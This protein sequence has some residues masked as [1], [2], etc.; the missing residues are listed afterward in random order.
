VVVLVVDGVIVVVVDVVVAL[1]VVVVLV[2]E[3]IQFGQTEDVVHDNIG[4]QELETT[5]IVFT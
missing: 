1:M 3:G 2:V 4:V 5:P